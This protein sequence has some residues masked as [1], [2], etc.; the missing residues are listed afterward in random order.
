MIADSEL[1]KLKGKKEIGELLERDRVETL[2]YEYYRR[3]RDIF[4]SLPARSAPMIAESLALDDSKQ[5]TFEI[6]KAVREALSE[7]SK[8]EVTSPTY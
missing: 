3:I 1:A 2:I 5:L 4:L 7:I 6:D 8:G